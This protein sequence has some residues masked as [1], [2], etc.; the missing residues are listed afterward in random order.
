[1]NR[2]PLWK[3]LLILGVVLIG[4]LYALP[5]LF[6]QDPSVEIS[7]VRGNELTEAT[8]AEL[9]S[10]LENADVP[11]KA[12]EPRAEDKLLVRF[13][14]SGDQLRGQEA[15]EA[16][17]SDRYNSAMTLAADLPGWL[18]TINALP[19]Y[20]GLDLRGGVQVL[21]DV[22][23]EAAVDQGLERYTGDIRSLLRRKKIRYLTVLHEGG[24]ITI[25]LAD[26]E[27]LK[28]ARQVIDKEFRELQLD[29][30]SGDGTFHLYA[31]LSAEDEEQIRNFALQQNITTL[32]N[33]VNALGVA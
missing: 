11:F 3:N 6:S 5:N 4:L 31:R 15:I 23:M 17:L 12:I 13:A 19:M 33:R 30:E 7:A 25:K 2:Y 9:R 32:R 18:R 20:L 29:T 14:S 24:R 10:A 1:M 22:D 16:T 28:E 26:A 8:P 21:I 27:M